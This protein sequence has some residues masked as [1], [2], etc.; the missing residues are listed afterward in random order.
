M[1]LQASSAPCR[2]CPLLRET[3]PPACVQLGGASLLLSSPPSLS[4]SH[5]HLSAHLCGHPHPPRADGGW[6]GST[7]LPRLPPTR[8]ALGAGGLPSR[9]AS[10]R[11]KPVLLITQD[12]RCPKWPVDYHASEGMVAPLAHRWSPGCLQGS[13]VVRR[14]PGPES[15]SHG[16]VSTAFLSSQ[17][18]FCK[19]G[20]I[21]LTCFLFSFC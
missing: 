4:P 11:L 1:P 16:H 10:R 6:S 9:A 13:H 2:C 15:H 21:S 19:T 8:L 3:L 20:I 14:Q 18:F 5:S 7:P 12:P 17:F